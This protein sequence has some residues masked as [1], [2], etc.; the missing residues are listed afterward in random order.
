MAC[1][2][3]F[4]MFLFVLFGG[5]GLFGLPL[6]FIHSFTRRPQVRNAKELRDIKKDLK[7]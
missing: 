5:V 7:R 1:I 2:T 4:G 3:F 6:G